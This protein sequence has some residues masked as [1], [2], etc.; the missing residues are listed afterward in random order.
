MK[1]KLA[2]N[3]AFVAYLSNPNA[4]VRD[5]LLSG[6]TS[7]NTQLLQKSD[8]EELPFFKKAFT[9]EEGVFNQKA[10]DDAYEAASNKYFE[11]ADEKA[12][13]NLLEWNPG[14][15]YTPLDAN[16]RDT[17][18]EVEHVENPMGVSKGLTGM[19]QEGTP[20]KT[21]QELAQMGK[22]WDTENKTWLEGTAESQS[23]IE[24][25]FGKSLVYA[26]Y[27]HE[28]VQE[29]P[30]TGEV[31][32]HYNGEFITDENGNYFTRTLEDD[33]EIGNNEVVAFSDILTKENSSINAIDFF[34]SD[35][36]DKSAWGV[37]AKVLASSLPYF[38]P[39]VAPYYGA[40]TAALGLTAV[41]PTFLKAID[42]I[43]TGNKETET[44]TTLRGMENWFR[45]YT[46]NSVSQHSKENFF[47]FENI[48][49]LLADVFG[50]VHQQRAAASLAK[51]LR[52]IANKP[53]DLVEDILKAQKRQNDL[54]VSL[55]MGYMGLIS[56]ANVY[57]DAKRGGYNDRTAGATALAS[58]A[59]L[60]GIMRFNST[61]RGIGTW[62]LD[63]TTG[64]NENVT[65]KPF[66]QL[67][68]K[69][70]DSMAQAVRG[71]FSPEK[72]NG[73]FGNFWVGFK[74]SL[75]KNFVEI[76]G[77]FWQRAMV[78]GVEE[79]SE[80]V[81]QDT[82]KGIT[83]FLSWCG[84]TGQKGSFGGFSNV[85]SR[86]GGARYL[87]TLLGGA[88][89]GAVFEFQMNH[90][91]PWVMRTFKDPNYKSEF[92]KQAELDLI[93]VIVNGQGDM[94]KK[95]CKSYARVLNDR[96]RNIGYINEKGQFESLMADNETSEAQTL[97]N[98]LIRQYDYMESFVKGIT[99]IDDFSKLNVFQQQGIKAWL[100]DQK[101][102][103]LTYNQEAFKRDIN[104]AWQDYT[105]WKAKEFDKAEGTN[106][107]DPTQPSEL[108][109]KFEASV[110]KVRETFSG[111]NAARRLQEIQVYMDPHIQDLSLLPFDTWFKLVYDN[112]NTPY[113]DLPEGNKDTD[114]PDALTQVAIYAKY[115]AY[116]KLKGGFGDA[117]IAVNQVPDIVDISLA[118]NKNLSAGLNKWI[119]SEKAKKI[120]WDRSLQD[121]SFDEIID[122][123]INDNFDEEAFKENQDESLTDEQ[124]DAAARSTKNIMKTIL[125]QSVRSGK[126]TNL[127]KL[128]PQ[129]FTLNDRL[130]IDL[131]SV[132]ENAINFGNFTDASK[133]IIKQMINTAAVFSGLTS[134]NKET[135]QEI[136]NSINESFND[137]NNLYAQRIREIE[138]GEEQEEGAAITTQAITDSLT[139]NPAELDEDALEKVSWDHLAEMT[140]TDH[141]LS[142]ALAKIIRDQYIV[143][144]FKRLKALEVFNKDADDA[145]IFKKFKNFIETTDDNGWDVTDLDSLRT[146]MMTEDSVSDIVDITNAGIKL[147][148][149]N[150]DLKTFLDRSKNLMDIRV[151]DSKVVIEEN[152]LTTALK[153][154]YFKFKGSKEGDTIFDKLIEMQDRLNGSDFT[155]DTIMFTEEERQGIEDAQ[156]TLRVINAVLGQMYV[157]EENPDLLVHPKGLNQIQVDYINAFLGGKGAEKFVVLNAEDYNSAAKY[158]AELSYKLDT[159]A[160]I[161]SELNKT[162]SEFYNKIRIERDDNLQ[163]LYRSD[164]L[165]HVSFDGREIDLLESWSWDDQK[166]VEENNNEAEIAIHK[167]IR[168]LA[169]SVDLTD[170]DAVKNFLNTLWES[171][172]NINVK[173][174]V[175]FTE[176]F[177][178]WDPSFLI[179]A[180]D[181]VD[182]INGLAL[183][184]RLTRI[185]VQQPKLAF[186]YLNQF[187]EDNEEFSPRVDQEE[188]L[189]NIL[190]ALN[191]PII[192]NAMQEV[193][194]D[195][196][197]SDKLDKILLN[198]V[199][200][201]VGT[202]GSGKTLLIKLLN[203][204]PDFKNKIIFSAKNQS[205]IESVQ[206]NFQTAKILKE[207]FTNFEILDQLQEQVE[208]DIL[209]EWG[210]LSDEDKN[211][212]SDITVNINGFGKVTAKVINGF[213]THWNF[214]FTSGLSLDT[215]IDPNSFNAIAI[216][217]CTQ[218]NPLQQALLS[219]WAVDNNKQIL[220]L[221]DPVQPGYRGNTAN[222]DL[223][224]SVIDLIT[225]RAFIAG[226]LEGMWRAENS[227]IQEL[228]TQLYS[229]FTHNN[230]LHPA[231]FSFSEDIIFHDEEIKKVKDAIKLLT[232]VYTDANK[233]SKYPVLGYHITQN[234]SE[235]KTSLDKINALQE[236]S[237]VI[238]VPD[239]TTSERIEELKNSNNDWEVVKL[240]DAQGQQYDYVLLQ[241][242]NQ[243]NQ[244]I[245]TNCKNLFMLLSR[246]K[247]ATLFSFEENGSFNTENTGLQTSN[248]STSIKEYSTETRDNFA[249]RRVE[250]IKYFAN[251]LETVENTPVKIDEPE[252]E[253]E[254]EQD[255]TT[256]A[257]PESKEKDDAKNWKVYG[258][259][260]KIIQIE[261]WYHRLGVDLNK[262]KSNLNG[263]QGKYQR[264]HAI[265]NIADAKKN[266]DLVGFAALCLYDS[267]IGQALYDDFTLDDFI[268]SFIEYKNKLS[269]NLQTDPQAHIFI[270]KCA[271]PEAIEEAPYEKNNNNYN[272]APTYR[273]GIVIKGAD[274][275]NMTKNYYFTLGSFSYDQNNAFLKD[276]INPKEQNTKIW[277]FNFDNTDQSKVNTKFLKQFQL[278]EKLKEWNKLSKTCVTYSSGVQTKRFR[279]SASGQ[280]GL[281][282][283]V[284]DFLR[285]GWEAIEIKTFDNAKNLEKWL[286]SYNFNSA[287]FNALSDKT[288]TW[289]LFKRKGTN[290]VY[291]LQVQV[292]KNLSDVISGTNSVVKGK[293]YQLLKPYAILQA[294]KGLLYAMDIDY[295]TKIYTEK[296]TQTHQP[297]NIVKVIA[298][299][300]SGET[301]K[302]KFD[303]F[304]KQQNF[305]D[306]QETALYALIE[307]QEALVPQR[308]KKQLTQ[309]SASKK[310][311][312]Q[313]KLFR[314]LTNLQSAFSQLQ[315]R[316][317]GKNYTLE[318][319]GFSNE[320]IENLQ[321]A[322]TEGV[323]SYILEPP[324]LIINLEHVEAKSQQ[325]TPNSV[326]TPPAQVKE[327]VLQVG[328]QFTDSEGNV[329]TVQSLTDSG[330]TYKHDNVVVTVDNDSDRTQERQIKNSMPTSSTTTVE[331]KAEWKEFFK[332]Y[333]T[334]V[335]LLLCNEETA[336]NLLK[337]Q[338]NSS[339]FG[340]MSIQIFQAVQQ[341]QDLDQD[342]NFKNYLKSKIE[343]DQDLLNNSKNLLAFI[344]NQTN[345]PLEINDQIIQ[346]DNQNNP[347]T[348]KC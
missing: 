286:N 31:D 148:N 63:K 193:T 135:I 156:N 262:V 74:K 249:K 100:S 114:S 106:T 247:R 136:I 194:H 96:R 23:I 224:K 343:N 289:V 19:N 93:D 104:A 338:A 56:A 139:L 173:Q 161:D 269:L 33:E 170:K 238:I 222:P 116:R 64:Y 128:F 260:A 11:M 207:L 306:A 10:F 312:V 99:G 183:F 174:G 81:V 120:A 29:N 230:A 34:D 73:A 168:A 331:E 268:Q 244:G 7:D 241:D 308:G 111:A 303:E 27:T 304:C 274:A 226:N 127:A 169:A 58:A 52:P 176:G 47:T 151:D 68:R 264:L 69:N 36:F 296:N 144:L 129:A 290:E 171:I 345:L 78:E 107:S 336:L 145:T 25:A 24:K 220:E 273:I 77:G 150:I 140:E 72:V 342:F 185:W 301:L 49:G 122:N 141:Y 67:A 255:D 180:N 125:V 131:A 117:K 201:L 323:I 18:F 57:D 48:G 341:F 166:S 9:N 287:E 30:I 91:Q 239:E 5:Y 41:M 21:P 39:G 181:K 3:D 86:E 254:P 53:T 326:N 267:N 203:T 35:G 311:D 294:T 160:R 70:Y 133:K 22:I 205:N 288:S 20:T 335:P 44:K 15:R 213:I 192:A 4:E 209:V 188:A 248:K 202:G 263:V 75:Y 252:E 83:D 154:I 8:Y 228:V 16:L 28:G 212:H 293:K 152:P 97:T 108:K 182:K 242:F 197:N 337:S 162:K 233:N 110:K 115:E 76:G 37:G 89:G 321:K 329:C 130:K 54:A 50:Q 297:Y 225:Y 279:K 232:P 339:S 348:P 112:L 347:Q 123:Y 17:S 243:K 223:N 98:D 259:D 231:I 153:S 155:A 210:K 85:F 215:S 178:F 291:P 333:Q 105:A 328:D 235:L 12:F 246:A 320:K 305:T 87:Q 51:Y 65:A 340:R 164:V 40:L 158:I 61:A 14:G 346:S 276:Y 299:L 187:C 283:K 163:I 282:L 147:N 82:V 132:I 177:K 257:L 334:Y 236:V 277:E 325:T 295:D 208:Q 344:Q 302:N 250:E 189:L 314:N 281:H 214:K 280:E 229:I 46:T 80:E 285:S 38:I 88:L 121:F 251:Q 32:M 55:Q 317:E 60:W 190:F 62:F 240:S 278:G 332:N 119:S 143:N 204:D 216:D 256:V 149:S 45:K 300:K 221:G 101:D 165:K 186:T 142:P 200:F 71:T 327:H 126:I 234:Q 313:E 157:G 92:E 1:E 84:F 2:D 237:K 261:Q 191:N 309:E 95:A 253:K 90:Y 318:L 322:K 42:S 167:N 172:K 265:L 79:V 258:D 146:W 94:Y 179:G 118:L 217:E 184:E 270:E 195:K 211:K 284:S 196:L 134:F 102:K 206:D 199:L 103:V 124:K 138:L 310:R 175:D 316:I 113:E 319:Y 137:E 66:I 43:F 59:A 198:N 272:K 324:K 307:F 266:R 6:L 159:L 227:A 218:L 109:K 315:T 219:K 275:N 298:K 292:A 26:K 271:N 330:F 13:Q 245:I